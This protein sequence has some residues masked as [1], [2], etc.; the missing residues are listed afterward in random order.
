MNMEQ[1]AAASAGTDNGI[2]KQGFSTG[3]SGFNPGMAEARRNAIFVMESLRSGIPT[4]LS[5]RLLP[6]LRRN[7]TERIHSDLEKFGT[8]RVPSGRMLWGQYGQGKTHALTAIEHMALDRNF[9]VSRVTL[10]REVSCHNLFHLFGQLVPRIR[11]A[12][13]TQ[14]GITPCLSKIHPEEIEGTVLFDENRY[15]NPLPRHILEDVLFA[16]GEDKEKLLGELSGIRL[17]VGEI[18][19]IHRSLHGRPLPKCQFKVTEHADAY[20]GVVADTLRLAGFEGWVILIDEVELI[21]RLGKQARLK[22]Y[23]NLHWMLNWGGRMRYPIY[24]VAAAASR[25]QDDLWYGKTDDDRT[26]MPE[27]AQTRYGE[28]DARN[29]TSF[30]SRAIGSDSMTIQPAGQQELVELLDSIARLH[31]HAYGW[32]PTFQGEDILRNLGAKPARTH[33]R[34]ALE[35]LDL[36]ML[37]ARE[38]ESASIAV[39]D[40][41]ELMETEMTEDECLAEISPE[42]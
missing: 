24:A 8:D 17:P 23:R 22:A 21:G 12:S 5:T 26:I 20:Y 31:G 10:S 3:P 33:V 9:A 34:A 29:I 40:S 4:R 15:S 6:D 39:P 18:G 2:G 28:E 35:Y 37:Y 16:E 30:F 11:T 41:F 13:S 42:E 36:Q 32:T 7:I 14:E 25:L 38:G 27:L 19:R 1:T